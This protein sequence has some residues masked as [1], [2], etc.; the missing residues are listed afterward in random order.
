MLTKKNQKKKHSPPYNVKKEREWNVIV[1]EYRLTNGLVHCS[2]RYQRERHPTL[3]DPRICVLKYQENKT[4]SR[5]IL[6]Y[7]DTNG[8]MLGSAKK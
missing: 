6:L 3:S 2:P 8:K 5:T 4:K 7:Y 1:F